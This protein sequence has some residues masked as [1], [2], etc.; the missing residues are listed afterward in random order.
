LGYATWLIRCS[1][2]ENPIGIET[3][4]RWSPV[5]NAVVRCSELENPIG[6]ET[7]HP[8]SSQPEA[9]HVAANLK[10]R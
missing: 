7:C 2:L 9:P 8:K 6:I 10:T 3:C 4:I 1:E 5:L